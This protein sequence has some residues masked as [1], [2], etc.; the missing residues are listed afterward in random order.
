M[1]TTKLGKTSLDIPAIALGVMRM[2][3][4][5]PEEGAAAIN[6]AYKAGVNFI[7]SADIYGRGNSEKVFG[8]ALK[9]ANV[10][11]E[12]LFIQSK[13]GIVVG[14]SGSHGS[15]AYGSRYEFTK[16]HILDAVDGI[17]KRM[18][19]NYLDCLVLHRPDILMDLEEIKQAFDI[20]QATGKVRFFGVS[21]FNPAQFKMLQNA[22]SQPLMFDQVQFGLMHT[23]MVDFGLHTNMTD[24]ASIN[25]DGSLL[26]FLRMN[27]IT[28]QA[29]SPFQYGTFAGTFINNPAF[30]E[31][32]KKLQEI[33]DKYSVGKNAVAAAWILKWPGQVQVIMGTMTP[34]HIVDSAK[35]ADI[36][37]TNQEW[38]DLYFAAGH[39]LP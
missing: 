22:V 5:T 4:R 6:A 17:L 39:D 25:H 32:N 28:L 18:D 26:E 34:A 38:Y 30:P 37:L 2:G 14:S 11:R 19:I 7:D 12:D 24:D 27:H 35:G 29:W 20:L 1:K 16:E 21:N 3:T 10:N 36:E 31:L 33:G 23:G 9:L 15:L 13:T 8:K